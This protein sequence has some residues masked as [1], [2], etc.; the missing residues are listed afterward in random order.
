MKW[1]K[2]GRIFNPVD[3]KLPNDC[4][5]FA[6]SPQALVFEDFVRIYFSTR[7]VEPSTGKFLSHIA[8][9]DMDKNFQSVLNIS[10]HPVISLG[11]LG[12]FDEHGI[13]PINVV[14]E[15][16]RILAYTCGWSR[17]SSVSVE[18]ST[19][20]AVSTNNGD[21]FT[22]YGTGPV[23]TASLNEPF[24][25][26]DAFVR[27][28]D[29]QYHMWYIYGTRWIDNSVEE[30]ARVYKIGHAVSHNG[31]EWKRDGKQIIT[32]SLN[33]DECQALPTVLYYKGRYHMFF[34]FREAIGF[35][36]NKD[37]EY[38]IGYAFSDNIVD[39]VHNDAACD[40]GFS[41]ED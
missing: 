18:T 1:Q 24:L 14:R 34:C 40:I 27:L 20:L 9:V 35:R 39:W 17:R 28:F 5:E 7:A 12:C 19:G 26:G 32:D 25:V 13:F 16:D 22:K 4:K 38:R 41:A 10:K 36:K 3:F 23:M 31:V 15:K 33:K 30:T 21:S 6:Q 2:L 11:G 29:G 8:F 37:R